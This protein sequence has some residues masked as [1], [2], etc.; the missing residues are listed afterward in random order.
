MA[1][2]D[3]VEREVLVR[4]LALHRGNRT[5]AAAAIGLTLRQMRYRMSRLG[6]QA[7]GDGSDEGE[8]G[9]A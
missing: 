5:A 2:L 4:A 6:V 7:A 1:H 9:G 8:E 3:E